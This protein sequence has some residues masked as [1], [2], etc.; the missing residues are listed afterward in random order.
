VKTLIN[1]SGKKEVDQVGRWRSGRRVRGAS[2]RLRAMVSEVRRLTARPST[3]SMRSRR[4]AERVTGSGNAAG[5]ASLEQELASALAAWVRA[6][7]A[8]RRRG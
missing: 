1:M 6:M 8:L 2:R 7:E 5:L 4:A 3:R